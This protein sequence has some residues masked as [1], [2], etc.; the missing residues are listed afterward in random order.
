MAVSNN[1]LYVA[2]N[3]GCIHTL[4]CD[5]KNGMLQ[6]TLA[7]LT[8][9]LCPGHGPELAFKWHNHAC[10]CTQLVACAVTLLLGIE[11]SL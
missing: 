6:V 11:A 3:R 9:P 1:L 5:I 8:P 7:P 2:D 4:R 10:T